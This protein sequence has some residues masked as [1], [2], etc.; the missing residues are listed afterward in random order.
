MACAD[1]IE[2]HIAL[3]SERLRRISGVGLDQLQA[4]SLQY[5][6][7]IQQHAPFLDEEIK[8]ISQGVEKPIESIYML[9]LRAELVAHFSSESPENQAAECTTFAVLGT[10][11]ANGSL[12]AGQNADLPSFYR[13]FCVVVRIIPEESPPVLMLTP[14]G[15]VSYIGIN[16][17]GVGVF[18]NYL[19]CAGWGLGFP[20]YLL[21][22]ALLSR[23]DAPRALEAFRAIPRASSRN[24]VVFDK[25]GRVI[26]IENTPTRHSI[27]QSR[28]GFLV[29]S[30]HYLSGE[31]AGEERAAGEE[32]RNSRARYRRM[33][34]LIQSA[35]GKISLEDLKH[36]LRDRGSQPDAICRFSSDGE[37]DVATIAGVIAEPAKGILHVAVGPPNKN[38]FK[39]YELARD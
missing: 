2:E 28:D 13:D 25:S 21:T 8:G 22:R 27:I 38:R 31:L 3:V 30:N 1:L 37:E 9:Q 35:P 36:F 23:E 26:D 39:V 34:E 4:L 12:M 18:G 24:L 17:A 19:K 20:R 5:R 10:R 32:L 33:V 16:S 7:Y 15:Q 14:A 11:S 29:H 6:P